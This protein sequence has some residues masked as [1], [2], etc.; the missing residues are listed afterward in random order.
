MKKHQDTELV[1]K[2]EYLKD[3]F[4]QTTSDLMLFL[5]TLGRITKINKA[6][7]AFSGFDEKEMIGK[8]FWT[9]PGVFSKRNIPKYLSVFKNSLQGKIVKNFQSTLSEKSGKKHVMNFSTYPIIKNKKVKKILVI[10]KDITHELEIAEALK[11][12]RDLYKL[13]AENT[14]D[15]IATIKF[16]STYTYLSP[17]HKKIW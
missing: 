10:G 12:T 13:I 11:K 15:L 7:I 6:G 5:D 17:S 9:V 1:L 2:E 8:L 16:D 14:S 3:L 4:F